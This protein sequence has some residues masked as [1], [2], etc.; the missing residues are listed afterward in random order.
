MRKPWWRSKLI[1][2]GIAEVVTGL[3]TFMTSLPT[4]ASWAFIGFGILKI[5]LRVVTRTA[6]KT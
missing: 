4:E 6:I 1:W 2:V 3:S 5:V